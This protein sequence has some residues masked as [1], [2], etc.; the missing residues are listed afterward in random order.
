MAEERL[1]A[2]RDAEE[3]ATELFRRLRAGDVVLLKASRRLGLEKA[4]DRLRERYGGEE[5]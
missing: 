4:I 3:V 1:L 5:T 2:V